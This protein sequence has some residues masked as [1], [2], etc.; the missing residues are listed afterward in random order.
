LAKETFEGWYLDPRGKNVGANAKFFNHDIAEAKK[1]V[2]AAGNTGIKT[3]V[4]YPAP[5]YYGGDFYKL[6]DIGIN[7]VRDAGVFTFDVNPLQRTEWVDRFLNVRG[8]QVDS[9]VVQFG[10]ILTL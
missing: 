3:K 2:A 9:G 10:D 8:G 5:P 7:M 1:L 4:S 6:A